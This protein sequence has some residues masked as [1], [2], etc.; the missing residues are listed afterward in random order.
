[1]Q[2]SK[3]QGG[4]TRPSIATNR[5]KTAS[6]KIALARIRTGTT[7]SWRAPARSG[8][9]GNQQT[10]EEKRM[11][12]RARK[13][14]AW[15]LAGVAVAVA[16]AALA[17]GR[18]GK[19][20]RFKGPDDSGW[21]VPPLPGV[22]G[23]PGPGCNLFGVQI[24]PA[25]KQQC[26]G[27]EK[28]CKAQARSTLSSCISGT[29]GQALAAARA[30]C[31]AAAG[32]QSCIDAWR[33]YT[34][35]IQPCVSDYRTAEAACKAQEDACKAA[36]PVLPTTCPAPVDPVCKAQCDATEKLC[37]A[38][39]LQTNVTCLQGCNDLIQAARTACSANPLSS[40]CQSALQAAR[41]CMTP[42]STQLRNDLAVCKQAE[43]NCEASCIT[44]GSNP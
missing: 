42:C 4:A 29:C 23:R 35:C 34:A 27:T 24:D 20:D 40:D 19:E 32:S 17:H 7:T 9:F 13:M 41:A 25:C 11:K 2:S 18:E 37:K 10:E 44:S 28:T 14:V 26:D 33:A 39:A 1:M 43:K 5:R 8:S 38:T 16:S 22:P 3:T 21:R 30:A 15:T 36:C 12:K 31:S 6:S